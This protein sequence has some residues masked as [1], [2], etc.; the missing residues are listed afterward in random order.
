MV[1]ALRA[2]IE[3]M[4]S[5]RQAGSAT[6]RGFAP[7]PVV[8]RQHLSRFRAARRQTL[9]AP[10]DPAGLRSRLEDASYTRCVLTGQRHAHRALRVAEELVAANRLKA[11]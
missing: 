3:E 5:G 4:R 10:E 2:V 6:V 7:D 11:T 9:A 8:P 1:E